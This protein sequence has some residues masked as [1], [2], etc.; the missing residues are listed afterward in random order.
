MERVVIRDALNLGT[1]LFQQGRHAE[2]EPL[3]RRARVMDERD[4]DAA[5]QLGNV[6]IALGRTREAVQQY[7]DACAR[8]A[9]FA[10]ALNNLGNA[11]RDLGELHQALGAYQAAIRARPDAATPINNAGYLLHTLHRLEEAEAMLRHGIAVAPAY[12]TLRLNLG[13]VLKDGGDL[14][15]AVEQYRAAVTLDPNNPV[16]HSNLVYALSFQSFDG[17]CV[18]S[19]ARRW[20]ERWTPTVAGPRAPAPRAR[21]PVRRLRIGYVSADFRDHCQ[22]LFLMPLLS[23]HDHGDFEIFCYSNV[24]RPDD[25]TRMI[26][27]HA[28]S[29]HEVQQLD[30]GALAS[31]I[32][33]DGIDVLV[34]LTMHMAGGRPLAFARKPARVQVAWLAYPGTRDSMRWTIGCPIP[35]SIHQAMRRNTPNAPSCSPIHSGATPR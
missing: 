15:G 19:E 35:V 30:D 10:P 23:N 34:D 21:E 6:L 32:R 20:N 29:W 5:Y 14:D 9:D 8:R 31:L 1:A 24:R 11:L 13:N 33:A 28:D 22:A 12:G 4:A 26:A 27:A 3:L 7:R 2:A 25:F 17:A 16:A 18:L